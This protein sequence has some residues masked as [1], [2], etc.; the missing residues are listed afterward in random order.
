MTRAQLIE[1][2]KVK[3]EEISPFDE[4][5]SFI[6]A[7]DNAANTVKPIISYINSTLDEAAKR[8]LYSLPLSLLHADVEH[9]KPAMYIDE[10]GVGIFPIGRNIRMVRFRHPALLRDITAFITTEDA[11]YLLQ[12][13]RYTRGGIAKPVAVIAA[14]GTQNAIGQMEIYSFP[15]SMNES[16]DNNGILLS[17]NTDKY[18]AK[19]IR[20]ES[21]ISLTDGTIKTTTDG[22]DIS[23]QA[24]GEYEIDAY[25]AG[26]RCDLYLKIP[27][28]G[29]SWEYQS[30][31]ESGVIEEAVE[32]TDSI[33]DILYT[34]GTVHPTI[35]FDENG[36]DYIRFSVELKDKIRRGDTI[37]FSFNWEGLN[38]NLYELDYVRCTI[39]PDADVN[40]V[41]SPIEEYI[42][43]ECAAMVSQILGDV[44]AAQI[45]RQEIQNKVQTI[46]Q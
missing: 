5:Q 31:N 15:A 32:V 39:V 41:K 36:G 21:I 45:C 35:Q 8:C 16:Q 22:L 34:L 9:S 24:G 17:I 38:I 6:A 20:T 19:E 40:I 11:L 26:S 29:L 43:L 28:L 14:N 10:H 18:A 2:V 3:L 46:L 33:Y 37:K 7:G 12:Q 30:E 23:Q 4:P 1:A 42:V 44:N 13:N 25:N 27:E